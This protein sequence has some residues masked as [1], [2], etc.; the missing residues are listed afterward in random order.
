MLVA[1]VRLAAQR[2]N[3]RLAPLVP[4]GGVVALVYTN[5]CSPKP[6][7]KS[8]CDE[9]CVLCSMGQGHRCRRPGKVG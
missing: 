6:H 7:S 3:A 5:L 9:L 8:A 2:V 1:Q 4:L